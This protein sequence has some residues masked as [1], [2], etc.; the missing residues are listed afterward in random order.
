V[1]R[2]SAQLL[3]F[4]SMMPA[5]AGCV[6]PAEYKGDDPLRR[7]PPHVDLGSLAPASAKTQLYNDCSRPLQVRVLNIIDLDS[8]VLNYRWVANNGIDNTRWLA[9]D[10]SSAPH[11]TSYPLRHAAD[12]GFDPAE[13]PVYTGVL[14]LFITDAP[15]DAWAAD[16]NEVE[17]GEAFDLG[18][19]EDPNGQYAVTEVRWTFEYDEALGEDVCSPRD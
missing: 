15:A 5:F 16:P 4:L 10:D 13:V 8:E 2:S 18:R 19:I 1:A 12:F 14:S 9:D 3:L 17:D 7:F 11:N 6:L